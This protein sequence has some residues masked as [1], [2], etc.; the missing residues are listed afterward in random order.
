M[1]SSDVNRPS[2]LLDPDPRGFRISGS[3]IFIRFE[4]LS[5]VGGVQ[6]EC[7]RIR[8]D[9]VVEGWLRLIIGRSLCRRVLF[10][11]LRRRTYK[12]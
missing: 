3:V 1:P 9:R 12:V 11:A 10:H 2:V 7:I 4:G 5:I 8:M 6:S